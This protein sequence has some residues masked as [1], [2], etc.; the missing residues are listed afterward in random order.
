M[1]A[2]AVTI[3]QLTV[4]YGRKAVLW[5]INVELPKGELIAL[6]GPNGAGKSTLLKALLGVVPP[7]SGCIQI[8]G[9]QPRKALSKMAY[10]PQFEAVDWDFPMTVFELVLMGCYRSRKWGLWPT[11]EEKRRVLEALGRVDLL[12]YQDHQIDKLSGG[13]KQRLF[14]ARALVHPC[15]I[16]FLDEPFAGIDMASTQMILQILKGLVE[17]GKTVVVVHHDL[18]EVKEHFSWSV[19]INRRVLASGPAKEVVQPD[20]LGRAYG[21]NV[22]L[23]DQAMS[24]ASG[25][26]EG[27]EES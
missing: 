4:H 1:K 26:N 10:V 22:E 8:L 17:A 11:K 5:N 7:L 24:L 21:Q 27:W 2:S 23:L 9:K 16:Y 25:K 19:L 15:E 3:K 14:L 6:I 20:I 12:P 18:E 13:Q